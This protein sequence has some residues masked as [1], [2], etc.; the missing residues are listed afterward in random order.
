MLG[1]LALALVLAGPPVTEVATAAAPDDLIERSLSEV[2]FTEV[3]MAP[4]GRQLAFVTRRDD[5]VRD[6]E[7]FTLWRLD[8]EAAKAA[9]VRLAMGIEPLSALRWSSTG[10]LAFL[11]VGPGGAAQLLVSE[12]GAA[13]PR[14]VTD[15]ARFQDGIDLYDWLPDGSGF[16]V[17]AAD[18]VAAQ[19][20]P[21][22]FYGDVRRMPGTP[23]GSSLSRI[24]LEGGRAE[25]LAA[26]PFELTGGL[27][28]SPDGRWIAVT[29]SDRSQT[30]RSSQVELLPLGRES[31]RRRRTSEILSK[32]SLAWAGKDL[33]VAGMGEERNRR[34]LYTEGRLFRLGAEDH[35]VRVAPGLE[36]YL[37]QVVGLADGSLLVTTNVSTRM[38]INRVSGRVSGLVSGT[39]RLLREQR[40]WISNLTASRDGR[41]IAFIAGD[42]RHFPEI[43]LA[44]GLDSVADARP[45]TAFNAALARGTLPEIETV[46]WDDG[47][48]ARVEGVLFWPPGRKGEKGLPLIVDLHGGPF[49]VARTEAVSLQGSFLSFPGVLAARGFLVLNPN[50]RGSAGRGDAFT[51]GI[52]GHRCSRPSED[53]IRGVEHLIG[54]GWA[55]RGR[56]GLIGYSGGGGL[57]KCLLGRTD[58]FRAVCTGAGVWNDLALFGTPRGLMWA[59]AFFNGIPPWEDS[60]LWWKESPV[61]G[62]GRVRTPTLILAGGRDG[63]APDQAAQLY[64]G[65]T[66]RGVP[67]ELLTFPG[68]G[69]V[70]TKPSHK[71]TKMRAEISWLEHWLLGRPRAEAEESAGQDL[72][73]LR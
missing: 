63:E 39:V 42:A 68:E 60:E 37:K 27:E 6:A 9:P 31:A 12:T 7:E 26:A 73:P 11:A 62:L 23:L 61:G 53:V 54:R 43:Y 45:V 24:S 38:R 3:A 17:A 51:Q 29:G 19:S 71:R 69:H 58:L 56:V 25:R 13:A 20:Q 66:A 22:D 33:F 57:S 55:D 52:Q 8:L 50:Y 21:R 2:V 36:G 67:A 14:R 32:E 4:D 49:S 65:L 5:T 40:G 41:R 48:G 70:F 15:P 35:L 16:I 47:A 64:H 10:D 44:G 18:P 72:Q 46:S 34:L 30:A 1:R 28:V 59:E